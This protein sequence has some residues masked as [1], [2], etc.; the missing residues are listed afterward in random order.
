VPGFENDFATQG[1][2]N[3]G[4]S[5][6]RARRYLLASPGYLDGLIRGRR[7]RLIAIGPLGDWTKRHDSQPL[8]LRSGYRPVERIGGVT[9]IFA[10]GRPGPEAALER[11]LRRAGLAPVLSPRV[12]DAALVTVP[13]PGGGRAQ[14]FV[15]PSA[16]RAER[17]V[18]EVIRFL[19]LDSAAVRRHGRVVLALVGAPR[20]QAAGAAERCA[21]RIA[22]A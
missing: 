3:A 21:V 18:P 8:I 13:L 7:V 2:L 16:T 22:G 12:R 20:G 4:Y 10:R 14:A 15:Y 11:C 5:D 19:R 1:V 17:A 6:A 9:T